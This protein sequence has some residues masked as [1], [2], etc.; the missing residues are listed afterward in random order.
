MPSVAC[1]ENAR[2]SRCLCALFQFGKRTA[3]QAAK[4]GR[5]GVEFVGVVGARRLGDSFGDFFNFHVAQYSTA[6]LG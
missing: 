1:Q 3:S 2:L 5:S 4:F 6:G